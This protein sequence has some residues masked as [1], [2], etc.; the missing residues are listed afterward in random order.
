[1]LLKLPDYTGIGGE[2]RLRFG[3]RS[4]EPLDVAHE[5]PC[6]LFFGRPDAWIS[7][8]RIGKLLLERGV[9]HATTPAH[10]SLPRR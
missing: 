7:G 8:P 9:L 3:E 2:Q 10:P 4:L 1:L 5:P 6:G